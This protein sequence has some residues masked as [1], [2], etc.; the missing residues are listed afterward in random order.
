MRFP[1]VDLKM[2]QVVGDE[3]LCRVGIGHLTNCRP[4]RRTTEGLMRSPSVLAANEFVLVIAERTYQDWTGEINVNDRLR[5]RCNMLGV[6]SLA[7]LEW[8]R[9]N[10]SDWDVGGLL[11]GV[12]PCSAA[13]TDGLWTGL[14]RHAVMP[15]P[16]NSANTELKDGG[17]FLVRVARLQLRVIWI[18][19]TMRRHRCGF[20]LRAAI[21]AHGSIDR[22][23]PSSA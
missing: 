19:R 23:L 3:R 10:R 21:M 5:E 9:T 12:V 13:T 16:A 20:R 22:P 6:V 14:V 4:D 15:L 18:L 7:D 1:V 11:H 2:L 8:T 17:V